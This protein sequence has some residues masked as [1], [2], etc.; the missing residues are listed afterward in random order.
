MSKDIEKIINK[1][2]QSAQLA[3][4]L[5]VSAYPKPGNVHRTADFKDTKYEHFLASAIAVLP[6]LQKAAKTGVKVALSEITPSQA[7]IGNIIKEGIIE[8]TKW[9]KGGNT[10]LGIL[11]LMIPLA[12]AEAYTL[13]KNKNSKNLR[14]NIKL[15]T[16]ATTPTD[17]INL[18]EAI[19]IAKPGGLGK[20]NYLDVTDPKSAT[21]IIS[22]KISLHTIFK[23][24]ASYDKIAEEWATNYKITFEIGA[25]YLRRVYRETGNT[26]IAIVHT[27]LKILST[28]PDTLIVR[29]T[30]LTTARKVSETA[31]QVLELGGLTTERGTKLLWKFDKELRKEGN[32]LN[33]GTTADLTASSLMVTIFNGFKP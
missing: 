7:E 11:I 32:K 14:K 18:Y 12:M 15:F 6:Q 22:Q 3:M 13:M 9:H 1:V 30:S 33:P 19:E 2:V 8:T 16:E 23:K 31:K 4:I 25:P 21:Q 28:I 26:N 20:T 10:N 24:S 17:T 5:E 27:F 29:K